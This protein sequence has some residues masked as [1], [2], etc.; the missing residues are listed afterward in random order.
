MRQIV[1]K[2]NESNQWYEISANP[3]HMP[4]ILL[5]DGCMIRHVGLPARKF[6]RGVIPL[7]A[8]GFALIEDAE[9]A[10]LSLPVTPAA[11]ISVPNFAFQYNVRLKS[12]RIVFKF[13]GQYYEVEDIYRAYGDFRFARLPDGRALE[14]V[15]SGLG[16]YMLSIPPEAVVFKEV[17][18]RP[19]PGILDAIACNNPFA[20]K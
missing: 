13:E 17:A 5:P 7:E 3:E 18:D 15:G 10:G 2:L 14:H 9:R 20:Q 6:D 12:I 1:F 16:S 8:C 19:L 11:K 4:P